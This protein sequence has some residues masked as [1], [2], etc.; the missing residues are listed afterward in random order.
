VTLTGEGPSRIARMKKARGRGGATLADQHVDDLAVLI[1]RP[2]EVG[3]AAGD[4]DVGLL[5]GPP[6]TDHR[7]PIA[8]RAG[9]AAS[10][11]SDV[12]VCTH[13]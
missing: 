8:C 7:A 9:R 13:R 3:P 5:H 6:I 2:V 4:F 10:M 12:N 1:H 11:K